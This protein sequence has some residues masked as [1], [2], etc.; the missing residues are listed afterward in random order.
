LKNKIKKWLF[1]EW[2]HKRASEQ[3]RLISPAA[4]F[5]STAIVSRKSNHAL[6]Y[7][8][9]AHALRFSTLQ[10]AIPIP[11]LDASIAQALEKTKRRG[12]QHSESE[13]HYG[14]GGRSACVSSKSLR[15]T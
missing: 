11:K 13:S 9:W 6:A 12:P 14:V 7:W 2:W 5:F 8:N 3:K 4:P 10:P 15:V 1:L